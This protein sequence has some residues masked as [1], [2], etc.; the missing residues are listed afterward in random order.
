MISCLLP[1]LSVNCL[2]GGKEEAYRLASTQQHHSNRSFPWELKGRP[3]AGVLAGS[4]HSSTVW[5]NW[6]GE[7]V[8]T[9]WTLECRLENYRNIYHWQSYSKLYIRIRMELMEG[10]HQVLPKKSTSGKMLNVCAVSLSRQ[11]LFIDVTWIK[12]W[13]YFMKDLC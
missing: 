9:Q 8:K 1:V 12:I 10:Q 3:A 4:L 6:T 11:C 7:S 13:T 5:L 2:A